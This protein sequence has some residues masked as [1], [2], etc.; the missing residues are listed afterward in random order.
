MVHCSFLIVGARIQYLQMKKAGAAPKPVKRARVE[1]EQNL[2]T[3]INSEN[4]VCHM[5]E[6]NSVDFSELSATWHKKEVQE[7]LEKA[8]LDPKETGRRSNNE[9]AFSIWNIPVTLDTK[10]LTVKE[11]KAE[12]AVRGLSVKGPKNLLV[13]RLDYHIRKKEPTRVKE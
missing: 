2:V 1:E 12:L 9:Q 4:P 8:Q 11:L 3:E 10:L 13:Q 7:R 6:A 5:R